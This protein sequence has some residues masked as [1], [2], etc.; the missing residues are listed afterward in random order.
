M[1]TTAHN[2]TLFCAL[3]ASYDVTIPP[4]THSKSYNGYPA[5]CPETFGVFFMHNCP[6]F[7]RK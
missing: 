4:H 5:L 7:L 3:W 1:N 2:Y 6:L